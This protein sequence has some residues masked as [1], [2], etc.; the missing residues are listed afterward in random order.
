MSAPQRSG[1]A[2]R[3]ARK[4]RRAF[5]REPSVVVIATGEEAMSLP[6][7]VQDA[8]T[9][10]AKRTAPTELLILDFVPGPA[11]HVPNDVK[12]HR[13]WREAAPDIGG[14][15]AH[16]PGAGLSRAPIPGALGEWRPGFYANGRPVLSI[17]ENINGTSIEHYGAA[18]SV[19]RRDE[20]DDVGRL[21]RIVDVDPSSGLDVTH[22]YIADD[23]SCWLS[24]QLSADGQ[25]GSARQFRPQVRAHEA[26]ESLQAEWVSQHF[27]A[28]QGQTVLSAG[29]T[30]RRIARRLRDAAA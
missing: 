26:L 2:G 27:D 13:F 1:L 11:T 4:L 3:A 5:A 18:G 20:L 10:K 9:Q 15:I 24:V 25:P 19:V 23:G 8:I 14:Y 7:S 28:A 21:V 6:T 12:V 30:S 22:R 16:D 29:P 17:I